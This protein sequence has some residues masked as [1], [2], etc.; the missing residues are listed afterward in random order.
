VLIDL[1]KH[2]LGQPCSLPGRM[3][4]CLSIDFLRQISMISE[5]KTAATDKL[6][7]YLERINFQKYLDTHDHPLHLIRTYFLAGIAQGVGFILGS[8]IVI[9]VLVY[10]FGLLGGV[11]LI[12][13]WVTQIVHVV[14]QN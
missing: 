5:N 8:T 9:A 13:Q 14:Q 12:G 2:A 7:T 10:F 6:S 3:L 11:P 1:I 4:C